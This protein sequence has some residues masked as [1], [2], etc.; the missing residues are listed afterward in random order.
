MDWPKTL[1]SSD[2]SGSSWAH[3]SSQVFS[4]S[5]VDLPACRGATVAAGAP[6]WP[7]WRL[8]SFCSMPRGSELS[9]SSRRDRRIR[10]TERPRSPSATPRP[11]FVCVCHLVV[12]MLLCTNMSF[13]HVACPRITRR[14]PSPAWGSGECAAAPTESFSHFHQ[15]EANERGGKWRISAFRDGCTLIARPIPG[16]CEADLSVERVMSA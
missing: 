4:R 9:T 2:K 6:G 7:E 15:E 12:M 16:C 5:L 10:W 1:S 14:A 11:Q 3:A 13:L 8:Y